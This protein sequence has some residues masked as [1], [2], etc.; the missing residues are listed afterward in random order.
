MSLRDLADSIPELGHGGR[1]IEDTLIRFAGLV[2]PS[3]VIVDI[4]PYLGSTTAYLALGAQP[5]VTIH[6]FDTWDADI[7]DLRAKSRYYHKTELPQDLRPLFLAN[8]APFAARVVTHQGDVRK[9]TWA[10]P[11]IG[12]FVDD[13]GVDRHYVE[14]KMRAFSSH[15]APG[16]VLV[17]M[18]YYWH[19]TKRGEAF[20]YQRRFVERN[21]HAFRFLERA[22]AIA[23]VF[24]W[25]G[26][27]LVY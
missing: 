14:A 13:I 6:A 17:L 4:G 3:E 5:G 21:A 1:V 26:G 12:L 11:L 23:A 10:G 2:H 15:F 19:E 8:L 18:D 20:D 16:A 9:V 25:E 24:E 7:C 27:A 22:G